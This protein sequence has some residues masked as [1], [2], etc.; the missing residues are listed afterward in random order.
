VVVTHRLAPLAAADEVVVLESGRVSARG[1][2]E[3]L[4]RDVASYREALRA[5]AG[6]GP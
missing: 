6:D 4:L 3:A 2:H 1:T 5:E